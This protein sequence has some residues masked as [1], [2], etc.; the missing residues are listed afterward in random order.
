MIDA[1][2]LK[3]SISKIL[4]AKN[5][6]ETHLTGFGVY[7]SCFLNNLIYRW[8]SDSGEVPKSLKT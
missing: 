1:T 2:L 7:Y 4:C 5:N 8:L 3:P 6:P